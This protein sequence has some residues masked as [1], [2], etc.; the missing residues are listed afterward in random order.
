MAQ[1][2]SI[3]YQYQITLR[4]EHAIYKS[5]DLAAET[6]TSFTLPPWE[7]VIATD[8]SGK[9]LENFQYET[10]TTKF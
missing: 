4:D 1:D 10:T 7:P 9:C 3:F 8:F 2:F 6:I 5:P